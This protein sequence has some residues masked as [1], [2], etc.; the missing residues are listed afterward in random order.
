MHAGPSH[1]HEQE[2]SSRRP[3][4]C[5]KIE[6]ATEPQTDSKKTR[7]V[8]PEAVRGSPGD[9]SK[10]KNVRQGHLELVVAI[11]ISNPPA[12]GNG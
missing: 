3:F 6:T 8:H 4:I 5:Q 11:E 2:S 12:G 1:A 10:S 9:R 7:Q